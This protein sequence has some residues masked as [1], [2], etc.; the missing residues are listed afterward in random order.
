VAGDFD[1]AVEAMDP[2]TGATASA[3]LSIRVVSCLT[4]TTEGL[5]GVIAG[6]AYSETLSATGGTEPYA[7]SIISGTLPEGLA[8]SSENGETSVSGTPTQSGTYGF[9]VLVTDGNQSAT[10]ILFI[11]VEPA[12][13][14]Q[15]RSVSSGVKDQQYH[16]HLSAAYGTGSYTWS[17]TSGAIPAGLALDSVTGEISGTPTV[18]GTFEF[19]LKV[20]DTGNPV[21]TTSA[22]F[23]ITISPGNLSVTTGSLPQADQLCDYTET[24][25]A[26]GGTGPYTWSLVDGYSLPDGLTLDPATGEISGM[27]KSVGVS[28]FV[29]LVTDSGSPAQTATAYIQLR[30]YAPLTI[31]ADLP[32][33]SLNQPY[34]YH[35]TASNGTFPYTWSLVEGNGTLPADMFLYSYDGLLYG[36]PSESGTF[37]F[38]A[39]VTDHEGEEQTARLSITV[40]QAPQVSPA[41]LAGGVVGR[42][43]GQTLT[44][45][46]GTGSYTWAVMQGSLP[47]GLALNSATGAITGTPAEAGTAVFTVSATDSRIT[48][49]AGTAVK[50]ITIYPALTVTTASLPAATQNVYYHQTLAAAGGAAPYTFAVSTGALPAGLSL[51]AA[52]GAITGLPATAGTGSFTVQVTD[53]GVP[54][55]TSSVSLSVAVAPAMSIAAAS[56]PPGTV[57]MPYSYTLSVQNGTASRIWMVG[58][59]AL[60]AGLYLNPDPGAITGTPAAAGTICFTVRVSETSG[61]HQTATR[62]FSITVENHLAVTTGS[63]PTVTL[64]AA[65][66]AVLASNYGTGPVTWAVVSG[67]LP[68]GLQLNANTG[69]L[70]GTP[71]AAGV[72]NFRVQATDCGTPVQ[73]ATADLSIAVIG[74][75]TLLNTGL[76]SGTILVPYTQTLTATGG[77]QPYTWAIGGTLPEG[78]AFDSTTGVI[79]GTPSKAG[80]YSFRAAVADSGV[81]AQVAW[82]D[83]SVTIA[84]APIAIQT[85]SLIAA[86][87]GTPYSQTLSAV[88]GTGAFTWV[89]TEDS[90]P[91]GLSLSADGAITGVPT[92]AGTS[93]F[94]V[95]ATDESENVCSARLSLQVLPLRVTVATADATGKSFSVTLSPAVS[96]LEAS[97]LNMVD[98][99]GHGIAI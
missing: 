1:F 91:D 19:T 33:A 8:L 43:Y 97:S 64:G 32:P 26:T 76:S 30:V 22:D 9:R 27:P 66:S 75:L 23:S 80:T 92:A 45:G 63:L 65:Y 2:S 47:T 79:S 87:F 62:V 4:V 73:T 74:I 42:T 93:S 77:K 38:T 89:V 58:Q 13:T 10:R 24:L 37:S 61:A 99:H 3:S 11:Q 17:V 90:L 85:A 40:Y 84:Y 28:Y 6:A 5:P 68:T 34:E 50:T 51:N 70:S 98:A 86:T 36:T 29:V 14:L 25:A 12:L 55:Q 44:A 72:S 57:G 88:G 54:H 18:E 60:P 20:T 78:L 94:T 48:G 95:Q 82:A 39:K 46:G 59:A 96:G 67:A 71:T 49:S 16:Q 53:S 83:F 56:L 81:N 69:I 41:A 15:T 7:W 21:Q 35:L 52:T 31:N